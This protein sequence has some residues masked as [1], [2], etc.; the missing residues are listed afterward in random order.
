MKLIKNKLETIFSVA[1]NDLNIIIHKYVGCGDELYLTCNKLRI[2]GLGLRT[3][4]INEA[5][6]N[7]KEIIRGRIELL[8]R[9][10][11]KFLR[12]DSEIEVSLW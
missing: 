2:D 1:D 4:N 6:K 9:E 11:E 5:V 10:S 12:D 8:V 7:A 3:T